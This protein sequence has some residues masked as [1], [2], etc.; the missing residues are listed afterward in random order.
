MNTHMSL[1]RELYEAGATGLDGSPG[2]RL[3][4]RA[5]GRIEELNA[6]VRKLCNEIEARKLLSFEAAE[7]I[8]SKPRKDQ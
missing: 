2:D 4:R 5:L 6:T 1:A 7:D 3:C 8:F